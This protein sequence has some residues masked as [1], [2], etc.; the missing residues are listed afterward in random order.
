MLSHA[1]RGRLGGLA[2]A[3]KHD[4]SF[5]VAIGTKGVRARGIEPLADMYARINKET[6]EKEEEAYKGDNWKKQFR[7]MAPFAHRGLR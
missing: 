4:H 2:T 7:A 5:Y 3:R 1:E 6:L